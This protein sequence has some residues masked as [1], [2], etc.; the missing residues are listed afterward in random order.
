MR[1]EPGAATALGVGQVASRTFRHPAGRCRTT[2]CAG[3]DAIAFTTVEYLR[4]QPAKLKRSKN[5]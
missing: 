4:S 3:L 5:V 2:D 1:H